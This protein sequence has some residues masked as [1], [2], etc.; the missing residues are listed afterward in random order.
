M[1]FSKRPDPAVEA[2][3]LQA[4]S[5]IGRQDLVRQVQAAVVA[6]QDG[7]YGACR[8]G[9]DGDLASL[10]RTVADKLE[11]Q[12][13]KDLQ[14]MVDIAVRCGGALVSV[15]QMT[16]DTHKITERS[17]G[18]AAAATEMVSSVQE[19]SRASTLAASESVD[20][21]QTAADGLAAS[22]RA[23]ESMERIARTV[24]DAAAKVATLE[25]ASVNIGAIVLEIEAIASQTN[26]L[27]LNATIE[28][29]RAGEAGKGFAVVAGEVKTL[30]SQTAKA[31]VDIRG[32]IDELRTEMQRI[33][34]SMQ[35]SS[36]A[37]RDGQVVIR[38]TGD[39]IRDA[40][41]K[42]D[43]IAA[44]MGEIAHI[45]GQQQEASRDVAAGI[46]DIAD[47]AQHS[48][49]QI[50]ALL[51]GMTSVDETIAKVLE[52]AV[53]KDIR[54]KVVQI[55]KADHIRFK[56]R[57]YEAVAGRIQLKADQ[58]ADHHSCRLGKW[59]GDVKDPI[60]LNASAFKALTEPHRAFHDYGKKALSLMADGR[61]D[62]ALK[63][64]ETVESLSR[65][66]LGLLDKLATE[67]AS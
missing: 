67:I 24:D 14:G 20:V 13:L 58:V 62:E 4:L 25:Q 51:D 26:L 56:K 16:Q 36:V 19:I 40:G 7:Q 37:V 8:A 17:Q 9:A 45:L 43:G 55:A 34:Q 1:F 48:S 30:A 59:V 12:D 33:V 31:T 61:T 57:L 39:H 66:V 47:M 10:L 28:A 64:I 11:R 54:G 42:I 29:A 3:R 49:H 41:T 53:Q 6:L 2:A 38:D 23:T 52:N 63:V 50:D 60:I 35:E 18:I 27:A 32:R 46:Q 44:R 22:A 15:L 5:D 65:D 21:R